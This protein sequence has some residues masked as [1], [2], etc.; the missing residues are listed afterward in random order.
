[1]IILYADL[2][3]FCVCV[4]HIVKEN[5][6]IKKK[7]PKMIWKHFDIDTVKVKKNTPNDAVFICQSIF[8]SWKRINQL[9]QQ[10]TQH[11]AAEYDNCSSEVRAL[12]GLVLNIKD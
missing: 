1:M 2:I 12:P 3:L 6:K 11:T 4:Y 9:L 8:S 10:M 5:L 7:D